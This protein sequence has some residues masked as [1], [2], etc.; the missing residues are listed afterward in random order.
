MSRLPSANWSKSSYGKHRNVSLQLIP[1]EGTRLRKTYD[2]FQ[3]NKAENIAIAHLYNNMNSRNTSIN[4]LI[5]FYGLDIRKTYD[6]RSSNKGR[7]KKEPSER[8]SLYMLVGEWKGA[9]YVDYLA[10]K[11]KETE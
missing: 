7:G 3:K 5:N 1:R 8:S 11:L 4:Q 9:E 6:A 2:L 10:K